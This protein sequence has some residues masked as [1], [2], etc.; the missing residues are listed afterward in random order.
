MKTSRVAGRASIARVLIYGTWSAF[1][2]TCGIATAKQASLP[3]ATLSGMITADAPFQAAEVRALNLD[4]DVQYMVFTNKGHYEAVA[5]LP[6]T[7]RVSVLKSGF[8]TETRSVWI[9]AGENTTLDLRLHGGGP[10]QFITNRNYMETQQVSEYLPYDKLYPAG[11]TRDLVEKSCLGCHWNDPS[12]LPA[13][14]RDAAEWLDTIEKHEESASGQ[15][16]LGKPP[17]AL[18]PPDTFAP[19]QLKTLVA[20]LAANSGLGQSGAFGSK[21]IRSH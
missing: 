20:Y 6:G 4:K 15:R 18:I 7:Y 16:A 1:L 17:F 8:W 2:L 5:L 12:Y 10:Q 14:P 21:R 3:H 19:Q 13:H 9:S 11:P